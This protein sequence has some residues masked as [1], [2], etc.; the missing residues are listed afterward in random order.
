[1][2][3]IKKMKKI[4]LG[5]N[6]EQNSTA[7]LMI[8]GAVVACS[9]E[10]RFSRI[11]NDERYPKKAIDW[12]LKTSNIKPSQIHHVCFISNVWSPNY[13]LTRHYTNFSIEDYIK[14]QK[15]YWYPK[16]YNNKK[17]DYLKI[18]KSK[19]DFKQYPS[20]TFWKDIFNNLKNKDAHVSN[21]NIIQYG[22]EIRTKVITHHLK[23]DSKKIDFID[24]SFGHACYAFFGVKKNKK[25]LILTLDAFGD[26]IN[27]SAHKFEVIKKKILINKIISGNNFIIARLYRYITLILGLKPNEHE[28]K[29]MGM[30]P[31]CKPKYFLPILK[32]FKK[33]QTVKRKKFLNLKMPKDLYFS[34]KEELDGKRFDAIS[35][36]LQ[37]YTEFLIEKW[38]LSLNKKNIPIAIA[39]GVALNVKS[40]YNLTKKFKDIMVPASPDDSSQAMG[41]CFAKHIN[42]YNNKKVFDLPTPINQ[43]YLGYEINED[44]TFKIIKKY[45]LNKKFKIVSKNKNKIAAQNLAQ[46]KIIARAVGKAEFGARSL[47]NRS[48]LADPRNINIKEVINEKV[49]NR[50]FWMPFAAT[51]LEKNYKKY[52]VIKDDIKNYKFMTKCLDTNKIGKT[53]LR[54]A[55]H[56]YDK[57]CRPQ[58]LIKGENKDYEDLL[59]SFEK[60][61]GVSALLNTSFNLHGEPIVNNAEDA[62][63]VFLKTDLDGLIL[64]KYL[65]L[66]NLK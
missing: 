14:E 48:I 4:I 2:K 44:E 55:L 33:Y 21:K 17:L 11:K 3:S 54:A 47:G 52:F 66:K 39:G 6:W 50:D 62:I 19:I 63:K 32:K 45:N 53:D 58:I 49:K 36:A 8:D 43:V 56:P 23:I 20:K 10:E 59:L 61:T 42:L 26:Y 35:G 9:S 16:I 41:A 34:I 60:I 64:D 46:G 13:I 38:L 1:M 29:V 65:I 7:A 15:K 24:H 5:I 27:Y 22:K 12:V 31:Y 28:Y 30:A 40:N 18:F 51:V 25:A 57:T 37:Q